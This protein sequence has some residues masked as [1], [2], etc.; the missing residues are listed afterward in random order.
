MLKRFERIGRVII[1]PILTLNFP[2]HALASLNE[3]EATDENPTHAPFY[4]TNHL[5]HFDHGVRL[6]T[7][8][9]TTQ[10]GDP[11]IEKDAN[12]F[13]LNVFLL[14]LGRYFLSLYFS[15]CAADFC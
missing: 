2:P 14:S 12:M 4:H 5:E 3:E 8:H 10:N 9:Q 13:V 15:S 11:E 1:D 6:N 7:L